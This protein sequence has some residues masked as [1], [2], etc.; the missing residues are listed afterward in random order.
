M[1]CQ[2]R[3][4]SDRDIGLKRVFVVFVEHYF[5]FSICLVFVSAGSIAVGSCLKGFRPL[6]S[7]LR[8]LTVKTERRLGP[9]LIL[10]TSGCSG[11]WD[12]PP[13]YRHLTRGD[14][15]GYTSDRVSCGHHAK[16]AGCWPKLFSDKLSKKIFVL[17]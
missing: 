9:L 3:R 10:L 7:S 2:K 5:S 13:A 15:T 17:R 12:I 8:H 11:C 16:W 1:K 4:R 6:D 14:N